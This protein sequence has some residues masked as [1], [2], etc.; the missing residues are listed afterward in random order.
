M[1]DNSNNSIRGAYNITLGMMQSPFLA[2][3]SDKFCCG[4]LNCQ[5]E[6]I[7][8]GGT[9][10]QRIHFR[11]KRGTGCKYFK[12]LTYDQTHEEAEKILKQLIDENY[13]IYFEKTCKGCVKNRSCPKNTK[14][15]K[16]CAK[17]GLNDEVV[18]EQYFTFADKKCFADVALMS[19]DGIIEMYEI[20][21]KH[22]TDELN[23]PSYISWYEL[24]ALDL[25]QKAAE[26]KD[27]RK[28]VLKCNRGWKCEDC[29]FADE[30][31][32]L[33]LKQ[34][35]EKKKLEFERICRLK[36]KNKE[37]EPLPVIEKVKE[38]LPVVEK[39]KEEIKAVRT[40]I[41]WETHQQKNM[42]QDDTAN[43]ID[44]WDIQDKI[45]N[46]DIFVN[47]LKNSLNANKYKSVINDMFIL[48][49]SYKREWNSF[50]A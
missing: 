48:Q 22:R 34:Q 9:P 37:E 39:V 28:I 2:R 33:E 35:E 10:K 42:P 20:Y 16:A 14:I 44:C 3:R 18:L 49:E 12:K 43:L 11:H 13:D 5:K 7:L 25:I 19:T 17:K 38:P 8:C 24:T 47:S 50:K 1:E 40:P 36:M 23:R 46:I 31:Y 15:H 27:N 6:V 32:I 41:K 30:Q 45:K 4:D 21:H 26:L 29:T